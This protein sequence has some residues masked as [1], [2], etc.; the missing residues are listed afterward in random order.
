M[1]NTKTTLIE[2]AKETMAIPDSSTSPRGLILQLWDI[3]Y[4]PAVPDVVHYHLS[5][6]VMQNHLV[7]SINCWNK[8][9]DDS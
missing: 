8:L 9:M 2:Y 1:V 5:D 3:I 7:R 6:A 4:V